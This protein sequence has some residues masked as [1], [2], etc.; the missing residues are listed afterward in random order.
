MQNKCEEGFATRA[1]LE[2]VSLA[3]SGDQGAFAELVRRSQKACFKLAVS[4][5]RDPHAAEDEVQ[6]AYWNAW[7]HIDGFQGDSKF[8]TWMTRIVMNQCLMR[9]REARRARVV[10]L[11]ELSGGED[12][13][14]FEIADRGLDPEQ[15][16][17]RK[18]VLEVL[19]REMRR[20]P[21]LLRSVLLSRHVDGLD[22]EEA[23]RRLGISVAAAK[24]RLLRAHQELRRRM[25][26][27]CGRLGIAT[28]TAGVS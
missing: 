7:R 6:N 1:E 3:R 26:R 18:Q 5:L 27:H 9:L 28:L 10:Y 11:E 23:A 4:V 16:L 25:E 13:P 21:P 12:R 15:E 24:S 2:L 22:N 19:Q 17:S 8:S 14:A 20:V